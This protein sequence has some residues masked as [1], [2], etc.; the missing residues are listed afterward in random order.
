MKFAAFMLSAMVAA[1]AVAQ[2]EAAAE[3][4]APAEKA[5]KKS[6]SAFMALMLC[7]SASG[8][9]EVMKPT[10]NWQ[11]AEEGKFYPLGSSFRTK[12]GS[13]TVDFGV[14]ASVSIG[15]DAS[16]STR[17]QPLGEASR[18]VIL[19]SGAV[20]VKLPDNL[21]EGAFFVVARGFTAKNPAGESK[22]TY[23]NKGDG[24]EVV[25]RCVTGSIAV[26][27]RHFAIPQMR[28]ADE[29]KIRTSH[30]HLFTGL[31]GTSGDYLVK[32]EQGVV[33]RDEVQDDGSVKK[34]ESQ[35]TLDWR[36]S[37]DT[38]VEIMRAVPALGERMS[39]YITTWDAAGE[40]Q[41]ECAYT[42]GRAEVNSGELIRTS[43]SDSEELAKRASEATETTEAADVDEEGGEDQNSS[44]DNN[45]SSESGAEEE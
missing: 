4:E 27:G 23:V 36:L 6:S 39:V 38:R 1:G 11:A 35:G 14:G 33:T 40:K 24:D 22:F 45:N 5:E 29:V 28:A 37:P 7:R 30:D 13:M 43:K 19:G 2:E 31:Y 16:F 15:A 34:I 42:E 25:V 8:E 26:D 12:N 18:T 21:P 44:N 32:L 17:T 10:M 3:T 20:D 9:C 41:N